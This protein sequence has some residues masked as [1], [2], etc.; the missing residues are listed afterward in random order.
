MRALAS[1]RKGTSAIEFAIALPVLILLFTGGFQLSDAVSAYR[2]V[3]ATSRSLADLTS[4]YTKVNDATLDTILNASTQVMAPYSTTDASFVISHISTDA[5]NRTTVD[6]SRAKNAT[7]L[8]K[9]D[10]FTIPTALKF[11][12]T[13][14]VVARV[15]YTYRPVFGSSYVG[16]IPMGD[17]IIMLPRASQS[18]LK[19]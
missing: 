19:E 17:T 11:P 8:N 16:T 1:D 7:A 4:Q 15:T 18:I 10:P 9:G 2:K 6:W 12:G 13:S 3:T 5:L 14:A